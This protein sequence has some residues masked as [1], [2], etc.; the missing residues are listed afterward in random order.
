MIIRQLF[1]QHASDELG[2]DNV[3]NKRTLNCIVL[4]KYRI[5]ALCRPTLLL[6]PY[7]YS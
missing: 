7:I 4:Y 1:S 2:S 5:L 6:I 3:F